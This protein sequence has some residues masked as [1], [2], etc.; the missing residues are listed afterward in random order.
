MVPDLNG[1][2]VGELAQTLLDDVEP[3]ARRSVV[4]IRELL[5][6]RAE[7]TA[8]Q[9]STVT[10]INA[11][12]V[13]EAVRDS[14]RHARR[15]EKP[16]RRAEDAGRGLGMTPDELLQVCRLS[17][18]VVRE[19]AQ[20]L[21]KRLT[22]TD[23]V[24]AEFVEA[25]LRSGDVGIRASAAALRE[26][27]IREL[28]QL[29]A[30]QA[31]LRRLAV[32]VARQA[33]AQEIFAAVSEE[34]SGLLGVDMV[35]IMRFESNGTTTVLASHG[36][37]KSVI[38]VGTNFPL[39]SRG[40]LAGIR[41]SGLPTWDDDYVELGSPIGDLLRREGVRVAAGGPMVVDGRLWGA[42]VASA[43]TMEALPSGSEGRIAQFAELVS[44]AI[45]GIESR[46]EVERLAAEQSSLRRV[47][48]LVAQQAASEAVFALVTE[49]LSGLLGVEVVRT[50]RFEP[51]GRATV[52]A[53]R[54]SPRD[55][56][57][58]GTTLPLAPGGMLDQLLHTGRPAH[59]EDYSRIPGQTSAI[60][61]AAGTRC[62]VG[63]PIVVDGRLWGAMVATATSTES[64]PPGS[65]DRVARFAQLVSTA[66]SNIESR[67]KVE[68]LAAEQAALRGVAE[69]V[70]RQ[71]P[72]AEVFA[73]ANEELGRLLGV[74]IV[75][76]VRFEPDGSATVLATHGITENRIPQGSNHP[77]PRGSLI[78]TVVRTGG[79]ARVDDYAQVE[80]PVGA[81]LRDEGARC[82]IGAPLVVDGRLW[83]AMTIIARTPGA[84][85]PGAEQRVTKFCEL[86]STAISNIESRAN[87]ERL[88]AEQAALRRVAELV[89]RQVPADN[90]FAL[91]TEEL[92]R[93][94]D[95]NMVRT[96][97]LE[98]NGTGTVVASHG[99]TDDRLTQGFNF[100]IP[101][102]S[103]IEK[104][105]RTGRPARQDDLDEVQGRIGAI[106]RE[107]GAA[108]SVGG[109]I[110]VDG[111]LWGAMA[112]GARSAE[113]L[114]PGCED[115]VAQFAELVSTAI[116]N[117]ESRANVE[118]L[119]AEQAA[120]R[121][122]AE[123]VA[124]QA[125][126]EQV[127]AL[128]TEELNGLLDVTNVGIAR[129]EADGTAT[130]MAVHGTAHSAFPPGKSMVL[131]G[132]S[133]I[134]RVYRTGR[135]AH[136]ENYND[137]GG[138]L[139]SVMRE[140]G[141]GWAAAGPIV[142]DGRLWGAM[143]VN[144]APTKS[145]PHG[146]E[147]RVAQ[148][149]ELVSTAIS[150]IESRAKVE[151]LAAEQGALRRVATLV[152]REHSPDD[153]FATLAQEV[154]V[155]LG[156]DASEILRYEGDGTATMV[157]GWSDSAI[158]LP[159]GERLPLEGENLAG[160]V[161]R[162]GLPGRKEDYGEATGAIAALSRE[163]GIRSA[164]GCPILVEGLTWGMIAVASRRPEPLPPDTEE[165]LAEFSRHAAMA[166]ANAKSRTD[167][168]ESRA[169]IVRT[170]DD[171]RRR[172]ERDLHDGAQ[173]RLVSMGFELREAEATVPPEF[174]DVHRVLAS[175]DTGLNDAVD[176]LREL[177][178][179]LHPAVLSEGGLVPALRALARRS[180]VPIDL[181]LDIDDARLEEPVEVTAYYVTS[182]ALTNTAKHA[183]AS[184]N[185]DPRGRARRLARADRERR[186]T[187]RRGPVTGPVSPDWLTESKPSAA[188]STSTVLQAR[189]RRSG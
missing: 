181:H 188:S 144:S 89:A 101:E 106:L 169:R 154:R 60:L 90:I 78:H 36:R 110:V 152:A 189:V 156:V 163:V 5:P 187:G 159:V 18:D 138:E 178:R 177:S 38:T 71:A 93:L 74:D 136:I 98:P 32:L 157:A 153:L 9:L 52:V 46:A 173:Q 158:S 80:G 22:M 172:F 151:R 109:P 83:G 167:L 139:G 149:A 70:A 142:V 113:A 103:V 15:A 43:S 87:V 23:G 67:E 19:E 64:L 3:I 47:A 66:I 76:T 61:R 155:L 186:R 1:D 165:R 135:P 16:L 95:V 85:G 183:H 164:V 130:V 171:A 92:S 4:R 120:L 140:L 6:S 118:R 81:I 124:G 63:G 96:V 161:L 84:F 50:V 49:E 160:E 10:L 129:F 133:M 104:V 30:E 100:E 14:N 88:A 126:P 123:L 24:L 111:R 148:F 27:G 29:A 7:L 62:A 77:I 8:D 44:A 108:A 53:A 33:Q 122:V 57:P 12:V 31:S 150:N 91:V 112:V 45:A 48:E 107:Q 54:G 39:P 137:V 35:R 82:G 28:E 185:R 174:G 176:D 127:F 131:E 68:R 75:K 94:L 132:G 125:P 141:A 143:V 102:G 134:E 166:V 13:L 59:F 179:G 162:T 37:L 26:S 34:L 86:I 117:I 99:I 72:P 42:M 58:P 55:P 11:R 170:T 128:V 79:T 69:L 114:P 41:R 175:L 105:F 146:A 65:E 97:R 147:D 20:I 119:A 21:A 145:Y 116:S 2:G 182:E 115:R 17:L 56:M 25:T 184:Q 168:A 180:A 121:R 73:R 51:D 40:V